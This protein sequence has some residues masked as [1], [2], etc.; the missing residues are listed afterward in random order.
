MAVTVGEDNGIII[1]K[2]QLK[3][4]IYIKVDTVTN[5]EDFLNNISLKNSDYRINLS[6]TNANVA[7]GEKLF[8]YKNDNLI[9]TYSITVLGDITGTGTINV[10]DV[11][12]LYQYIQGSISMDS[13]YQMAGDVTFDE[14]LKVNDVAKLY[15][16]VRGSLESLR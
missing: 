10:S 7:T 9:N 14:Q 2:Y 11:A 6:L 4:D 5:I 13:A 3:D 15:Q 1:N 8:V 12:K 16:Y